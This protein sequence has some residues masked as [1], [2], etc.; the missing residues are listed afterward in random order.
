M[1]SKQEKIS[2]V[3]SYGRGHQAVCVLLFIQ[4]LKSKDAG[5]QTDLLAIS[6]TIT[7]YKQRISKFIPY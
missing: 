6:I 7:R 2:E 5:L 1:N 4:Q 3:D